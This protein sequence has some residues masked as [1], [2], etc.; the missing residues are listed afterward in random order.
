M[1]LPSGTVTFLFTDIEGSTRLWEEHPQAMRTALARHDTLL[2]QAITSSAGVVFKTI[3]DAFCAAFATAPNALCAA[4]AAQRA[5]I[6]EP[7]PDSLVLRVRMALHTG[8][9]ELRDEDYFGQSLN[10][11]ARL[12]AAGHGG[13][14]LLSD[15]AHDLTRDA[16][17]PRAECKPLGEHRLRDLGRPEP[18]FQLLHPDLPSVFP[19]LKSL[20]HPDL[21]NNLPRQ[22]TS[23]IGREK[24]M[25]E[26][27]ALLGKTRLLT[28]TG[29]GGCGK[30]RL[31]LQAA[32]DMLESYPEGVWF[33]ELAPLTDPALMPQAVAQTLSLSEE[34]G[35]P[36][37]QTVVDF[38]K[39]RRLLLLLDNCEHLLDA[40]ARFADTVLKSSLHVRILATSREALGI[41]GEQSY[42]IPSLALPDTGQAQTVQSV[43]GYEAARL[44][45]ER[46][47]AVQST[48]VVTDSSA[49]ALAQL[50]VRLD[51]IPFAIELAAA[52][53]RS[54]SV[55]EINARLDNRFRLLTGGS[56]TAL[57][58]QQTLRALIDWS[59]DLLPPRTQAL[60]CRLSVFA[61]GWTLEAAE[62]VGVDTTLEAWEVLDLLTSL[63]DKSL[64]VADQ[65]EGETRFRLLETVRQY[66]REGLEARGESA[67][68]RG[69][70]QAFFLAFA[71][72]A[73]PHL[74]GPEGKHQL[75][76]LETEHDNLRAAL[77][78]GGTNAALRI[79]GALY[80]FWEVRGYFTEGRK[81]LTDALAGVEA[82]A[83]TLHRAK[84]LSSAGTLAR[85]QGDHAAA[86]AR[87]EES[88]ALYREWND[89]GGIAYALTSLG[90]L[91]Y[92]QGDYAGARSLYEEGLA[93]RQEQGDRAGLAQSLSNLGNIAYFQGDFVQTRT[94]YEEGLALCRELGNRG[95]MAHS[96]TNLGLLASEQGDYARAHTLLEESLTLA[97]ELGN[98]GGIAYALYH[99]GNLAYFQGDR[100]N[101]RSL[102]EESLVLYRELGDKG[103]IAGSFLS[104]GNLAYR[105]GD[106][107]QAR[108]L[109]EESLVLCQELGNR[110][111][112]AEA[113][114][115]FAVLALAQGH[116]PRAAHL[117]GAAEA[118]R[119]ALGTP[120]QPF[121][122]PTYDQLVAQARR[123]LGENAFTSAWS[124]GHTMTIEEAI[125]YALENG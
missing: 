1:P 76:R 92:G 52:R 113:L 70:H 111:G 104:L 69:R 35:K 23:F 123:T 84:A 22:V 15:V 29:S 100:K 85:I 50:C 67:L 63:V 7:W 51:G 82:Q 30:T 24:E 109:L 72:S 58:R 66:A 21:P 13:Q 25:A 79:A 83:R 64:L 108:S 80:P 68:V 94:L 86:R 41:A 96:L 18:V 97:R 88:L 32:A 81:R 36:L 89:K 73:E 17:P 114:E 33:V 26:I 119:S 60:L 117:W 103:G 28:L 56:R 39:T 46:A 11:V 44:F 8:D 75:D 107:T 34:P 71:E 91:A 9:A 54:L 95:G 65:T 42:R 55:A 120:M 105:Q 101:A 2:R 47:V 78:W 20:D 87:L 45:I 3:G 5:L 57:P 118:L 99:L 61:G 6:A 122:R 40:C 38:L 124:A 110:G 106:Y 74:K 53:V 10:R 62:A 77:E 90:N 43:S 115:A 125:A 49:S 121:H 98:K 48:F 102:W 12:L 59:F 37:V 27:K 112:I 14:T 31:G 116:A 93:L 19:P 16:L 4:L